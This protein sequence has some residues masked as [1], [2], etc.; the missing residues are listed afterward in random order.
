[1]R[2]QLQIHFHGID[3]SPA[4]EAAI[5]EK[6]NK[7]EQFHPNVTSCRVVVQRPHN[8]KQQGEEFLVSIDIS[9]PGGNIVTNQVRRQDVHVALRDAFLAAR[10]QLDEHARRLYVD[11]KRRVEPHPL[12]G[13]L[14]AEVPPV[15]SA[16]SG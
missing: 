3:A 10:R 5:R 6:S 9:V 15:A 4:L 16:L 13:D 8:H 11:A 1:M 7:L 2:T 12:S 14:D